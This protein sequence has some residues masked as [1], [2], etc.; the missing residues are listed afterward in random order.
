MTIGKFTSIN[1]FI[2][3]WINHCLS[4]CLLGV[5]VCPAWI[6]LTHQYSPL[7]VAGVWNTLSC[8][9]YSP[10]LQLQ[11]VIQ[12]WWSGP[13]YWPS[14]GNF[15]F[16]LTAQ[17]EAWMG[18][19]GMWCCLM[20]SAG[21]QCVFCILTAK[22]FVFYSLGGWAVSFCAVWWSWFW[23]FT[24]LDCYVA[25][26]VMTSMLLQQPEAASPTLGETF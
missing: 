13:K 12:K 11:S 2:A 4:I 6:T 10:T 1:F 21:L 14:V 26:V 19:L 7:A 22:H 5:I 16:F 3:T 15:F 9:V 17:T 18:Q 8:D 24:I 25:P 20:Y 23:S